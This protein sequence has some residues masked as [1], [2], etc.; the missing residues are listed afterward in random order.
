M[1]PQLKGGE[2]VPLGPEDVRTESKETALTM[3]LGR[4]FFANSTTQWGLISVRCVWRLDVYV[5]HDAGIASYLILDDRHV[6]LL[7]VC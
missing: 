7:M 2:R 6:P 5:F 4:V 1:V 3:E